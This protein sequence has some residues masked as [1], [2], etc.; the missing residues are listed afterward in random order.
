MQVSQKMPRP[1]KIGSVCFALRR[2]SQTPST[3]VSQAINPMDVIS[4][5]SGSFSNAESACTKAYRR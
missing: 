4:P 2:A 3:A 5:T 1:I